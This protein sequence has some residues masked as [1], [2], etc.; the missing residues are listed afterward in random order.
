MEIECKVPG[1]IFQIKLLKEVRNKHKASIGP[2]PQL[3]HP[4]AKLQPTARLPPSTVE[5]ISP[6]VQM[7]TPYQPTILPGPKPS[8]ELLLPILNV[9]ALALIDKKTGG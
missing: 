6:H 5:S 1:L 7:N 3:H 9:S 2:N 8:T 4:P